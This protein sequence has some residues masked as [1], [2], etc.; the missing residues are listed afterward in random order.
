M[1]NKRYVVGI[2]GCG[3]IWNKGHWPGAFAHLQDTIEVR[4]TFDISPENAQAAADK[5]GAQ[6]IEN[7]DRI[8][9][10][11][12]VDIV[13]IATP[14]YARLEYVKKACAA[15]K[16]IMLEKPMARS[17][18]DAVAIHGEVTKAGIR[19]SIPFARTI[20]SPLLELQSLIQT[21]H[22]G[23][24]KGFVHSNLGGPYGWIPLDHWMHDMEKSGGPIFDYSIHFIELARACMTSE[25]K[26]VYY[27]GKNTTDRVKSDDFA[28]LLIEY[29]NGAMGEFTKLWS[30]PPENPCALQS[31]HV[32]LEEAVCEVLLP[33]VRIFCNNRVI[34][35]NEKKSDLPGRAKGYLNLIDSIENGSPLLA[36]SADGLRIAEI[37]DT[38]FTSRG[39]GR[40]ETV[41][42]N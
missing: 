24:P 16:H 17:L 18:D 30:F 3:D 36:N 41:V 1:K 38:A 15:G 12:E 10:D 32:V 9:G 5:S 21:G 42:K 14:P 8:F 23:A 7:P 31:T 29:E 19:C 37:L 35:I 22:F 6:A 20:T 2:I 39:S 4:Y 13:T 40:K 26:T 25:A 34:E 28:A 27:A 11:S 33:T